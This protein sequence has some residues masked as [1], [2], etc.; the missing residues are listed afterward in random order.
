MNKEIKLKNFLIVLMILVV[1]EIGI[2]FWLIPF[3]NNK[4]AS[5]YCQ[6]AICND[7]NSMCRVYDIDADGKTQIIWRGSCN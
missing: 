4:E 3:L 6:N 5:K 1:M 7:D 2:L